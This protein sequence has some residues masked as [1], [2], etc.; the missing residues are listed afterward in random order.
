MLGK[1]SKENEPLFQPIAQ[2]DEE[3]LKLPRY[4]DNPNA[5]SPNEKEDDGGPS[6]KY[7]DDPNSSV[8]DW[9]TDDNENNKTPSSSRVGD[10]SEDMDDT[11]HIGDVYQIDDGAGFAPVSLHDDD[12]ID[13][14]EIGSGR[15][16]RLKA[17]DML[18]QRVFDDT[19]YDD[20][21]DR[22]FV[23]GGWGRHG[24]QFSLCPNGSSWCCRSAPTYSRGRK[25]NKGMGRIICLMVSFLLLVIGS[26]FVGYEAGLPI[27]DEGIGSTDAG[28]SVI[29]V[30][31]GGIAHT[32]HKHPHTKGEEWLGWIEHEKEEISN[33]MHNIHFNMTFHRPHRPSKDKGATSSSSGASRFEPIS[34]PQLLKLSEDI[35][36]SCSERSL[37][38]PVGRNKCLSLCQGRYCCF[39]KDAD[40]GSCVAE[41]NSYCFA[42]AA[43]ENAIADFD[44]NNANTHS[45]GKQGNSNFFLGQQDK[46]LLSKTC[47]KENIATSQG[48]R[49]CSVLCQHHVCCFNSLENES[50]KKDRVA[51]C[52]AYAACEILV[53]DPLDLSENA[54][55]GGG[56]GPVSSGTDSTYHSTVASQVAKSNPNNAGA[57]TQNTFKTDCI[58][59]NI[60]ENWDMCKNHCQ[61]FECCFGSTN[62]CYSLQKE[63]CDEYYICEEFFFTPEDEDVDEFN[64]M[65]GEELFEK[66]EAFC[67]RKCSEYKCCYEGTCNQDECNDYI[68][69]ESFLDDVNNELVPVGGNNIHPPAPIPAPAP[70]ISEGE[71]SMLADGL[72]N[73]E[74]AEFNEN[75]G[76]TGVLQKN[77]LLCKDICA[78][79]ECCY[80]SGPESCYQNREEECDQYYMC[81]FFF[82]DD[83]IQ[84]DNNP[85]PA[86]VNEVVPA[87]E[88]LNSG[89]DGGGGS[90]PTSESAAV[91]LAVFKIICTESNFEQ[92]RDVCKEKCTPFKCCFD[93]S[94]GG[95]KNSCYS[96]RQKECDD[97]SICEE[98][99]DEWDYG[100][101]GHDDAFEEA[102]IEQQQQAVKQQAMQEAN[103]VVHSPPGDGILSAEAQAQKEL[104]EVFQSCVPKARTEPWLADKCRKACDARKCC[105]IENGGPGSC[106]FTREAWCFEFDACYDIL[107]GR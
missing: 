7:R 32:S 74:L 66:N 16:I 26:S 70:A 107:Y 33:E 11:R 87:P 30:D 5:S 102:N 64:T 39:E 29:N 24:S 59:K 48:V 10:E 56:T 9:D 60:E 55:G 61:P 72:D 95:E 12:E 27:D 83:V 101:E 45:I 103:N 1:K 88:S 25:E 36:Q 20:D 23:G 2:D 8:F 57:P 34:Q 71:D 93:E 43:C 85:T 68:I 51:E 78:E 69:C 52:E 81:D 63:K 75:C 86:V 40:F 54:S 98:F 47:S 38:S 80:K 18:R 19:T 84:E 76:D 77:K 6:V 94:G 82:E 41:P 106:E 62:S 96:E 105:F 90:M 42:Y 17:N 37:K 104:D 28:N 73:K 21:D 67:R 97:H 31:D 4:R 49:D 13:D 14:E 46:T 3:E 53:N 92:N 22:I 65:C 35:F 79:F 44:M 89:S 50:C 15:K 58:M 91:E 99:Y 100:V